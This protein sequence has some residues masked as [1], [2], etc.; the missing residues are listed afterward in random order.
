M[1]KIFPKAH[2]ASALLIT[3]S[4][5]S[6]L[7]LVVMGVSAFVLEDLGVVRTVVAGKQAEY[8][9]EGM[10]EYGLLLSKNELPGYEVE[11]TDTSFSN[12]ARASLTVS[13]RDSQ[14]PC[15]IDGETGWSVLVPSE[16]IQLP[17]FAQVGDRDADVNKVLDFYVS[18][19][20]GDE[21]GEAKLK[22]GEVLRW[23]I[24]GMKRD[25]TEAISAFIPLDGVHLLP[26]DPSIFGSAIPHS[27]AV[28]EG[29]STASYHALTGIQAVFHD[30]Y[31]IRQFLE[32]HDFNY[33]VLTN[34][35][36]DGS[37][38]YYQLHAPGSEAACTYVRLESSA[39]VD[40]GEARQSIE[41]VIREGENLPAFDFVLYQT[42]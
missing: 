10:S 28:P 16:S 20:V 7:I 22:S 37:N 40:V 11:L 21:K 3:F 30:S 18:F 35:A 2:D 12:G 42:D 39:Q 33:L 9:A 1:M 36:G 34:L 32:G 6:L 13:A 31:P 19:Y 29:Y 8:A 14:V 4:M 38:I 5:T 17:L 26:E 27:R 15:T 41:T 24:L 25:I 23:K